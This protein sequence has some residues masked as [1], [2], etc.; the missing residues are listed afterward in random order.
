MARA[1]NMDDADILSLIG[2]AGMCSFALVLLTQQTVQHWR[3]WLT[4]D[5]D[6]WLTHLEDQ[7]KV[8]LRKRPQN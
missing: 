6:E 1:K 8:T 2:W 5:E 7:G 4:S 3:D